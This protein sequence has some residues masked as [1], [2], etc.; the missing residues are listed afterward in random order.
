MILKAGSLLGFSG[1]S[2]QSYFI[3]SVTYGIPRWGISH[4]GIVCPNQGS[5][6]LV[7]ESTTFTREPCAIQGKPFSGT[8]AHVIESRVKGYKGKVYVYELEKSLTPSEIKM[9]QDYL[10]STIGTPYD[11]VGAFRA[12][13]HAWSWFESRLRPADQSALFCSEWCA[14]A[15]RD[16]RRFYTRSESKWNPNALL[17][18]LYKRGIVK[19]PIRLK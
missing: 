6:N 15:L 10:L 7:F 4:V 17:R 2:W 12:G 8:Q 16:I 3:N 9:L 1:Y 18:T 13:G 11:A 14:A 19:K 5:S